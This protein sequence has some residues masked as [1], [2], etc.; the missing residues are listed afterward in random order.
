MG[1]CGNGNGNGDGEDG[2]YEKGV[3]MM[4]VHP[5]DS[6]I[7]LME[8]ARRWVIGA[9]ILCT[10]LQKCRDYYR[11]WGCISYIYLFGSLRARF[12]PQHRIDEM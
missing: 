8:L 10:R 2:R 4:G 6:W 7:Q 11:G 1:D 9:G 12:Y 5:S 3:G